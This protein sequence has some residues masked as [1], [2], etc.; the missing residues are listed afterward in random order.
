MSSRIEIV[1]NNTRSD[2]LSPIATL[3][4]VYDGRSRSAE[5]DYAARQACRFSS[6]LARLV[7]TSLVFITERLQRAVVV[8][9]EPPS[10]LLDKTVKN[11]SSTSLRME[12][13]M[14]NLGSPYQRTWFRCAS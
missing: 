11:D 3:S 7:K 5:T 4:D 12:L 13:K 9:E 1:L 6:C 2:R 8:E 14:S 10:D